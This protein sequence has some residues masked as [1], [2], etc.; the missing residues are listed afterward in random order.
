MFINDEQLEAYQQTI[1]DQENELRCLRLEIELLQSEL[2]QYR[3]ETEYRLR[4]GLPVALQGL[5]PTREDR[6]ALNEF[7]DSDTQY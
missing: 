5:M 1:K 6:L 3:L 4:Q 7:L 2:E